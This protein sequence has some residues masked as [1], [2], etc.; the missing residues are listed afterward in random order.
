MN[1]LSALV[2]AAI[3]AAVGVGVALRRPANVDRTHA[4]GQTAPRVWLEDGNVVAGGLGVTLAEIEKTVG[5]PSM[6]RRDPG[7]GRYL[8]NAN[9]D[10]RGSLRLGRP[11]QADV[12]EVLEFQTTSCGDRAIRVR[13]GACLE[14]FHS[15][16]A[17]ASRSLDEKLC[18]RGYAIFGEGRLIF[19]DATIAYMSGSRARPAARTASG[20]IVRSRFIETDGNSFFAEDVD[21]KVVQIED[22]EFISRGNYGFVVSGPGRS[23]LELRRCV[24]RGEAADI[25]HAGR[26]AD[27]MLL[28]CEF[29]K[30]RIRFNQLNGSIAVR[31][32][33]NVQVLDRRGVPV[34]DA[35][36]M[37]Q[38]EPSC[39]R[40][41][42]VEAPSRSDKHG[43]TLLVL[44]EFQADAFNPKRLDRVN[45]QTPHRVWA[46]DG[47]G[48]LLA[49]LHGVEVGR[50]GMTLT[51]QVSP[52]L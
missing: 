14:V 2:V 47:E 22:C 4:E 6:F 34:A 9:L 21:G 41:E 28:D 51:L 37:A 38:S 18:S 49:E 25:L 45:N 11:G 8:C 26:D 23:P 20:R 7:N 15:E 44:T 13:E 42:H 12:H 35:R 50:R 24:L 5:D 31:W 43:R 17:T 3:L 10:V 32:T 48:H 39:G 16:I 29:R 19:E 30:D 1:R 33:L 27:A 52:S 46:M 40:E 36:V